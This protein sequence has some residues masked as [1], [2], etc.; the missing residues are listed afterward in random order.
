MTER[1]LDEIDDILPPEP[2]GELVHWMQPRPLTVGPAGIS[3]ATA[4]AFAIG[5]LTA[6]AALALLRWLRPPRAD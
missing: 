1:M 5:A 4:A 2:N 6:V 3:I